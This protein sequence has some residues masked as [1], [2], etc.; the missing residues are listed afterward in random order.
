M[1]TY[2]AH[3]KIIIGCTCITAMSFA[4]VQTRHSDKEYKNERLNSKKVVRYQ[5]QKQYDKFAE[6]LINKDSVMSCS[7]IHPDSKTTL[8]NGDVWNAQ[9]TCD[10]MTASF[11]QVQKTYKVSFTLDTIQLNG[12]TAAV[13][14]HQYWHRSQL[15]AGK[16]RD[17]ETTADQ[18]ETWVEK[19]GV[20][21]RC[22]VDR[23]APKIW[24]VDGKRIDPSKPYNPDAPEYVPANGK[25]I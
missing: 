8:P 5:L 19:D 6:A 17:V 14:I 4:Q 25:N 22:K 15:K 16:I 1:K 10:Y 13:L 9:Q 12:D 21:L 3:I 18:W 23:V 11:R 20:Y 7:L 2:L 24:K